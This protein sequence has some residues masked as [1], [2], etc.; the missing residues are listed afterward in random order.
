MSRKPSVGLFV[1]CLIDLMRPS[2]GFAA[3]RLLEAA[4]CEV[5]VPVGQTCCG[6]PAFNAGDPDTAKTLARQTIAAFE[7]HDYVVA[8][9]GS[10]AGM[11]R[12]HY[13]DLLAD[14]EAWNARAFAFAEKVHELT[15]F[16]VDVR[17]ME[18]VEASFD[19]RIVLHD[20]CS[21]L[22]DLGVCDQPRRLL[23]SVA[24]ATVCETDEAE[25]QTC[26]GFGGTFAVKYSD[27]STAIANRK[28]AALKA[29]GAELLV[30]CD[31]GCLLHVAGRLRRQGATLSA[32][33]IAEVLAGELTAPP[34]GE[35]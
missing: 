25:R 10:C 34:I 20:S 26:C 15:A 11:L 27:I 21:G 31:L 18:S 1:T 29:T 30:S 5:V 24:G 16:L 22:R 19:G 23:S 33:H 13:P 12:R 8:A 35:T 28:C 6:Q 7:R 9:S 4:D 3:A 17:G 32:R 2:V 14:D